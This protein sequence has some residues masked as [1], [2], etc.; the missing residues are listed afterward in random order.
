MEWAIAIALVP[1]YL[2]GIRW[3]SK[4]L[5][6]KIPEGRIKRLLTRKLG[7]E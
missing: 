4:I 3:L 6:R 7:S 5:I 2:L 1:L